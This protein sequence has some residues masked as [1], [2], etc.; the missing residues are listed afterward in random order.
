MDAFLGC[1]DRQWRCK[2]MNSPLPQYYS[3][4]GSFRDLF[5]QGNPILTY[6]KLG[7][8]P[9]RVRLKGLY[10]SARLFTAQLEELRA[11][12]FTNGSL[13]DCAGPLGPRQI[14]ITF[15][16]GYVNVL[17]HALVPLAQTGF[18]A[19]Q[20]LPANLLGRRNEWDVAAGE[21]PEPIMDVAQ[22][23]EW[24][25]AGQTIGSH[26]LDHPRL[27]QLPAAGAREQISSSRKK[28]EDLFGVAI[29]HF[30]YPYGD[31]N[32]TVR[33]LVA[34]AGYRTACTTEAG[35]N[36]PGDSP[37]ELKRF[38]ARYASR[39]LKTLRETFRRGWRQWF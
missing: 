38:T 24:L 13:H 17:R 35:M 5:Q 3:S 9:A 37:F 14:V 25:A 33:D 19:I 8:R 11:A 36:G 1:V 21:A 2:M 12:G 23:R 27:T 18:K 32:P 4:L 22:V 7:P 10:V 6:H 30:C 31:W 28:L 34:A 39:N 16:D 15:D 26:T 20:F 29:E